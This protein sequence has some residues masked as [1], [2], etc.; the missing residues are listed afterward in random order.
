MYIPIGSWKIIAR[1]QQG[2]LN[3]INFNR[4]T[5]VFTGDVFGRPLSDGRF[6]DN[7]NEVS[8]SVKLVDRTIKYLGYLA[9][10]GGPMLEDYIMEGTGRVVVVPN[11]TRRQ[12]PG[13]PTIDTNPWGWHATIEVPG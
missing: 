11:P 8:F 13:Q 9:K 12:R 1:G 10:A 3:I 6:N 2:V 5:G 4:N 7:T